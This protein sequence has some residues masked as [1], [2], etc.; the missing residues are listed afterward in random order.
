M[1][2][3]GKNPIQIPDKVEVTVSDSQNGQTVKVKGPQGELESTFRKEINIT[4]EDGRVVLKRASDEIFVMCLHG[5]TRT[6]LQNMILGVTH[7]FKKE[8]D[9]IGVGYR[10]QM[11]GKKLV[12]QIGY[13]HQIGIEA[14]KDTKI[15]VDKNQTHITVTGISK[16]AVGDLAAM[17]RDA[18]LPEPY[19]GKGIKYSDERIRRK[20]G[21]SAVKK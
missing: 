18:R 6:M 16:Q 1:S 14:P 17:I 5:T 21:K 20:A 19:K 3:I 9:I 4:K 15:E 2:R 11:Q 10:A 13:S 7:G 12:L 8:L